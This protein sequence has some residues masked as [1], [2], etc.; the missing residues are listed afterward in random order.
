M[1]PYLH[2]I[3]AARCLLH[4]CIDLHISPEASKLKSKLM[5]PDISSLIRNSLR[6]S[7][8]QHQACITNYS[9]K[10]KVRTSCSCFHTQLCTSPSNRQAYL[11]QSSTQLRYSVAWRSKLPIHRRVH[12]FTLLVARNTKLLD[13]ILRYM[14][15]YI[16]E[17]SGAI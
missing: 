6:S 8:L 9:C 12:N 13:R 11:A 5:A 17:S 16:C 2:T 4:A 7:N 10:H 15:R 14:I 1:D 3:I